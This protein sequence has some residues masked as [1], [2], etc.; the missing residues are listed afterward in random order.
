MKVLFR[1]FTYHRFSRG[2]SIFVGSQRLLSCIKRCVWPK[3]MT[4]QTGLD[5]GKFSSGNVGC[6]LFWTPRNT[7]PPEFFF[8]RPE[9][10]ERKKVSK[11]KSAEKKTRWAE[12]KTLMTFPISLSNH[13][14]GF[15]TL[16]R[17]EFFGLW[18]KSSGTKPHQTPR[19]QTLW[20]DRC[21][22]SA[23]RW[24][25]CCLKRWCQKVSNMGFKWGSGE[26]VTF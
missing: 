5:I 22:A 2:R 21:S 15:W 13:Q 6:W 10:E 25:R 7:T 12:F 24:K 16:L 23:V 19:H 4:R 8:W 1:R 14:P 17:C 11:K 3:V 26:W 9:S 20:F 18:N